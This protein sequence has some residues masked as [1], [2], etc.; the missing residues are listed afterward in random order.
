MP[1]YS[2]L[3]CKEF[4]TLACAL[5]VRTINVEEKSLV[6]LDGISTKCGWYPAVRLVET[7]SEREM[8]GSGR[9]N[10]NFYSFK[11]P[12]YLIKF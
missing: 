2:R 6:R 10:N 8:E 12:S 3:M 5:A 7:G 11:N 9:G 1:I 4:H